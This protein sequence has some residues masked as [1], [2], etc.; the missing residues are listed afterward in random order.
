MLKIF[1]SLALVSFHSFSTL[2]N[3]L[4]LVIDLFLNEV[5]CMVRVLVDEIDVHISFLSLAPSQLKLRNLGID[6]CYFLLIT[7]SFI[8]TLLDLSLEFAS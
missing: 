4:G 3:L 7:D 6:E 2:G 8:N 1:L 5:V